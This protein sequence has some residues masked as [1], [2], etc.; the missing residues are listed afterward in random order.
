MID[1]AF[2]LQLVWTGLV[3]NDEEQFGVLEEV[4]AECRDGQLDPIHYEKPV[5][6]SADGEQNLYS[7]GTMERNGIL[8]EMDHFDGWKL[9]WV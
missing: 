9:P 5:G 1:Q 2:L 7:R 3:I 6:L 4:I 8:N